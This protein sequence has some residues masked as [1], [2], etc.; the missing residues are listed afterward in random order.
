VI[1]HG[2]WCST[3]AA[4]APLSPVEVVVL[5]T[6]KTVEHSPGDDTDVDRLRSV[7][8]GGATGGYFRGRRSFLA[9]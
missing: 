3:G 1:G 5:P 7:A 6:R 4:A 8:N 9:G 2:G